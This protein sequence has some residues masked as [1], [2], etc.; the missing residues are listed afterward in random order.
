M[1]RIKERDDRIMELK[2]QSKHVFQDKERLLNEKEER[3]SEMKKVQLNVEDKNTMLECEMSELK[4]RYSEL[5]SIMN[6]PY[7]KGEYAENKLE[8]MLR[9]NVSDIFKIDNIGSK[10]A[11]STDIHLRSRENDGVI[12]VESK[13]Y[14]TV[15]KYIITGEVRKFLNDIDTCKSKMNVMSAVFVSIACDIPTITDN[16]VYRKEKGINCYYFANMTKE[17]YDLLYLVLGIEARLYKE[18]VLSEGNESMNRFLMR[19]FVEITNNYKRISDL[20]PGYTA[21]KSSVEKSER[22]YGKAVKKI[23]VDIKGLSENFT[24]LTNIDSVSDLDVSGLLGVETPHDLNLPQWDAYKSELVKLRVENHGLL[25]NRDEL[26]RV[27]TIIEEKESCITNKD[28][29]IKKLEAKIAEK[30]TKSKKSAA[31]SKES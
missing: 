31:K 3:I 28:T 24:K 11:H 27:R 26:A 4:T 25:E 23:L 6:N 7:K 22:S 20:D 29:V 8:E 12:L 10:E 2:E 1:E 21:I 9:D 15:S 19:N 18:R 14:S 13:F 30:K 5:E 16:F 17:K